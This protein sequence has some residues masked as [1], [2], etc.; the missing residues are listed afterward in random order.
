MA[1]RSW[2]F[3]QLHGDY[4]ILNLSGWSA[5]F[6]RPRQ[7]AVTRSP[8]SVRHKS[9]RYPGTNAPP[10]RHLF[11]VNYPDWELHGRFRDREL[12][13]GGA[14]QKMEY[15]K[16]FVKDQQ[17]CDITWGNIIH[18]TGIITEFDPGIESE[19]EIEWKMKI[20]IDQDNTQVQTDNDNIAKLSPTGTIELILNAVTPIT[21][22]TTTPDVAGILTNLLDSVDDY[23]SA[24]T[25]T[26]GQL[27]DIAALIGDVQSGLSNEAKRLVAGIHQAKTAILSLI[28]V[29][30][31]INDDKNFIRNSAEDVLRFKAYSTDAILKA[32]YSLALLSDLENQAV[33]AERGQASVNVRVKQ[34]D[35]WESISTRVLGGPSEADAIRKANGA[36]F[37]S[38]PI[39]GT[40]V[41][42]PTI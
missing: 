30:E 14:L 7:G 21:K 40:L 22:I 16:N 41:Q 13:K 8:I 29:A 42:I 24:V 33:A 15:V 11:G 19:S 25:G 17:I 18:V 9:T 31:A 6:G 32:T 5:P 27:N 34:G 39:P 23:V 4:K 10:T 20:A 38:K 2:T 26:I 37:G 36:K 12:G 1:D 35:T 28:H 3:A